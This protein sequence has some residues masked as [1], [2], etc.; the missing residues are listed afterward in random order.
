MHEE[1]NALLIAKEK[2]KD[3]RIVKRECILYILQI[4][5]IIWQKNI[6]LMRMGYSIIKNTLNVSAEE[7][8]K[9]AK[10]PI[11]Q[12]VKTLQEDQI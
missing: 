9:R 3:V 10:Y 4:T 11:P 12:E 2:I 1:Y 8:L 7:L 6:G 5:D